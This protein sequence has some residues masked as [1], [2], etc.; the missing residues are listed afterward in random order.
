MWV[1]SEMCWS[2]AKAASGVLSCGSHLST[3]Q[4]SSGQMRCKEMSSTPSGGGSHP[5]I[6]PPCFRLKSL[7]TKSKAWLSGLC[8]GHACLQELPPQEVVYAQL[9]QFRAVWIGVWIGSPSPKQHHWH[10]TLLRLPDD[11]SWNLT[12]SQVQML[13]QRE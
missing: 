7:V 1:Y 2:G 12:K 6:M 3:T 8:Q 11:Q 5:D 9:S 13:Q 10:P 4:P